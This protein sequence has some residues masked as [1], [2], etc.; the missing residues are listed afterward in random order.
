MDKLAFKESLT[1]W[2]E[3][4]GLSVLGEWDIEES[5][6]SAKIMLKIKIEGEENQGSSI[7]ENKNE[8]IKTAV[9]ALNDQLIKRLN[10]QG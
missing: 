8:T 3:E 7:T 4:I 10:K 5:N 1:K 6:D 2:L 9:L